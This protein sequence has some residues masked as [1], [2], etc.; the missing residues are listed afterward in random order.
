[1][2][3]VF[4]PPEET[5]WQ[6]AMTI[7]KQFPNVFKFLWEVSPPL[8]S[9]SVVTL[10][11]T[12]II[13]AALIW[14]TKDIVDQVIETIDLGGSFASLAFPIGIMV[15]LWLAQSLVGA[16]KGFVDMLLGERSYSTAADKLMK[17]ATQL[18]VAFFESPRFYDQ[19]HHARRQL[20]EIS[21]LGS[22]CL[23]TVQTLV[24]L[25]AMFGLLSLLHPLAIVVLLVTT[26]P[27]ILVES[28]Q[29]RK[30]FDLHM[31][32]VRQDRIAEYALRLT[33]DRDTVKEVRLFSLVPFLAGLFHT[34]RE[35]WIKVYSALQLLF[36]KINL[37]FNSL[38]FMGVATV[39]LYAV[40]QAVNQQITIG[41]LT[42][43]F[44]AAQSASQQ[45]TGLMQNF[46][47]LYQNALFASRFF[48]LLELDPQEVDGALQPI[49]PSSAKPFPEPLCEGIEFRNVSFH[50]PKNEELVLKDVSFKIPRGGK[51]AIVGENGAGKTTIIKL[52]NRFYDPVEGSVLI[53]GIDA[54]EIEPRDIQR[55]MSAIYQDFVRY[56]ISAAENIGIGEV[57]LVG[58]REMIQ[59]AAKRGGAHGLI[60]A[61]PKGYDTILGRTLDEGV[62]LSGGEWQQLGISRAFMSQSQVLMLD[63]P[64]AA[65]DAFKEQQ[66]YDRIAELTR[67]KTLVFI[68]H[69]FST[70]RMADLIV[71][72][73]DGEVVEAGSHE[74]LLDQAGQYASMFNTQASRYVD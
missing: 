60:E 35:K 15:G 30:R 61:L 1:M 43:V 9:G 42:M 12:A 5:F 66:L 14:M 26:V 13:P 6:R 55:N 33:V 67:E 22:S 28:W 8:L 20:W 7:G 57:E 74:E 21:Q 59:T 68:S 36:M 32:M 53:D 69:R 73:E 51:V 19:L 11:I 64:T 70:V 62:D 31:E 38:S 40:Y 72:I 34:N 16:I 63:E 54:K 56:D 58:D 52:L 47:W 29:A 41:E 25:G 3:D 46:G 37:G 39:W 48:G 2:S 23:N 65:L 24:G 44:A 18:D 50:Y 27:R 49:T 45:L 4:R 10:V 71:V 17:K